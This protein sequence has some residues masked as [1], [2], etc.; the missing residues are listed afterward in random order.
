MNR[1]EPYRKK[2]SAERTPE[3]FGGTLPTAGNLFVVQKHSATRLHWDLRLEH[4]GALVSWAVPKGPS[5]D[6]AD[7]RLAMKVEDHPIEYADFEGVI[8][9]GQYGA[10]PVI[11]WDRGTWTPVGD[12]AEGLA[13]G[14]LK[15]D[16]RGYKLRGRWTL[17]K[18]KQEE[19]SWL[20]IKE[21]DAYADERGTAAYPDD[22]IGSGLTVDERAD[23]GPVI[24]RIRRLL[25]E[26]GAKRSDVDPDRVDVMLATARDEPFSRSGWVFEFKFDGYRIVG[27]RSG[28][29]AGLI[30]RNGNDLT[31][32]FPEV[33][34]AVAAL[35]YDGLVVDGEVVVHDE[36]GIP[37]FDRLQRRGRLQRWADV[38]RAAVELPATWYAF[39]LIACEG[40]DARAL[41]LLERKRLLREI[42]PS[43]GPIRFSDHVDEHGEAVYE[44]AVAM[45]LEGVVAKKADGPYRGTRSKE[46]LKVRSVRTDDY[47]VVGWK[48]PKGS[49][50]GFGSLHLARYDG[51][52]LVYVGGVGT[53]F[54]ETALESLAS[55]LAEL[56]VDEPACRPPEGGELPR[57]K[58]PRWVRPEIV[59]EVR[60]KEVTAQGLLRH[61]VFVRTRDDKAPHECTGGF[62]HPQV[63]DPVEV[64][65]PDEPERTIAF[66]NLDK[67]LWPDAG[68]TKGDLI[69]YYRAV[70]DWMLPYLRDRPL[71]LTRYPDGI[72]GKSFFQK[73]APD[74]APDWLRT[75][76][77]WSEGS[78]RELSYFV[79]DEL[80]QL[81][82]I[83]NSA[84]LL[85][86]VWASRVATLGNPDWCIMD[87]DPKDAPFEDVVTI[88]RAIRALC[89]EIDLP[90]FVKT[91]GGSGLHLLIP[92]GRQ[93]THEQARLL[94]ELVARVI[95]REN[96]EIATIQRVVSRREGRVYVDFLQ[97]GHGKLLV[98]PFSSRPR[99]GATVSTPLRWR[100]VV[101]SLD[102]TRFTIESVPRRVRAMK[103]DPLRAVLDLEPDLMGALERLS[104]RMG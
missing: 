36:R 9:D 75:A 53:G 69:D 78:E 23:P 58:A 66:T 80:D 84:A 72:D 46:W 104:A 70:A 54:D 82:W 42:L 50:T 21:A 43:A 27:W 2:R 59:V 89:E 103:D 93:T 31:R 83:A 19:N 67:V 10:G 79:V 97:N 74:W 76:T 57:G 6:P 51:E 17:V 47:A 81:L 37:S 25:D 85:L 102:P 88:A 101:P 100:E 13:K 41:P 5:A 48:A 16:L 1:L 38:V 15:F 4:D 98:A 28:G 3:P 14:T 34:R 91:S 40:Y 95:V 32:T 45:G 49:R 52:G 39:D 99:P 44:R 22:S 63:E 18:T 90:V 12:P 26:A 7:K 65:E 64:E 56:E 86:H 24:E 77:I 30:S 11:V 29:E 94:G 8:P 73:D 68:Y 61:P 35:P 96:E 33:A 62:A 92:L 71:V 20:L 87:L 55:R 60:Y